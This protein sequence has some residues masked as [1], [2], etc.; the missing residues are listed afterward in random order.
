MPFSHGVMVCHIIFRG[1]VKRTF[2]TV[3]SVRKQCSLLHRK[4]MRQ[5]VPVFASQMVEIREILWVW[6]RKII[7][8]TT[9]RQVVRQGDTGS[10]AGLCGFSS[11]RHD[12]QG[13]RRTWCTPIGLAFDRVALF[14]QPN[15]RAA[16]GTPGRCIGLHAVPHTTLTRP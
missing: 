4:D 3:L 1:A 5:S 15:T 10:A 14:A 16:C 9:N 2:Y 13:T 12:T 8:Q 7:R 6:K 11:T